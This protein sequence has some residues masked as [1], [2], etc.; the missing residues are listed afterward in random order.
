[1]GTVPRRRLRQTSAHR[2]QELAA[3]QLS[4]PWHQ[5]LLASMHDVVLVAD[6]DGTFTY[7]SPSVESALG[8]MPSELT[9][10]N[11]RDL[12][13]PSDLP[14]HERLVSRLIETADPQPPIE[15]RLHARDGQDCSGIRSRTESSPT[16]AT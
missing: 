12:I 3:E 6:V 1:M 8:Y 16:R 11:E 15:L 4:E 14:V 10:T 13:H 9:G 2:R 7:C 5:A